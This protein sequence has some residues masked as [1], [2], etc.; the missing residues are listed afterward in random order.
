M[1]RTLR[2]GSRVHAI[3]L[4]LILLIQCALLALRKVGFLPVWTLID[5]MQLLG[6]LPLLKIRMFPD[7]NDAFKPALMANFVILDNSLIAD[8]EYSD[9][10]RNYDNYEMPFPSLLK[11]MII[12]PLPVVLLFCLCGAKVCDFGVKW[13]NATNIFYRTTMILFLP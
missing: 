9:L 10:S 4:I 11:L 3:L 12:A 6:L 7:V 5:Y 8:E 2:T 1:M 13:H